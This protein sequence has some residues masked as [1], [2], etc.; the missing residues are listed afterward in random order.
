M[1]GTEANRLP[2]LLTPLR[3]LRVPLSC[4][5]DPTSYWHLPMGTIVFEV[6]MCFSAGTANSLRFWLDNSNKLRVQESDMWNNTS[7]GG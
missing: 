3:A 6:A 2:R 1:I 5:G 4:E 7:D